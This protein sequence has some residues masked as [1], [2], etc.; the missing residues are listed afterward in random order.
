MLMTTNVDAS[1]AAAASVVRAW[2]ACKAAL[3]WCCSINHEGSR[4]EFKGFL[5][6]PGVLYSPTS[7]FAA[8]VA[9]PALVAASAGGNAI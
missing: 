1:S 8:A 5:L 2:L 3:L 6:L 9:A 7:N 4:V